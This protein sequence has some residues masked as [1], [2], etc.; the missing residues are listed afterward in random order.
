MRISHHH[1]PALSKLH[2]AVVHSHSQSSDTAII[3]MLFTAV[4]MLFTA[5]A[6]PPVAIMIFNIMIFINMIFIPVVFVSTFLVDAHY[7]DL[8]NVLWQVRGLDEDIGVLAF[9]FMLHVVKGSVL[10]IIIDGALT[11]I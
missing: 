3:I 5:V 10:R 9:E 7:V 11:E 4:V 6:M 2:C 1:F 8:W